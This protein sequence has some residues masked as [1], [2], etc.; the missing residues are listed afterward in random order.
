MRISTVIKKAGLP[1]QGGGRSEQKQACCD[2]KIAAGGRLLTAGI[3]LKRQVGRAEFE[4]GG[5]EQDDADDIGNHVAIADAPSQYSRAGDGA[6]NPIRRSNIALHSASPV[7]VESAQDCTNPTYNPSMA[8]IRILTRTREVI[9]VS[10]SKAR[11]P[12]FLKDLFHDISL[13]TWLELSETGE[14]LQVL[15]KYAIGRSVSEEERKRALEQ[16]KDLARTIPA[17]G[18]FMLPGGAILLP[19]VAK[20][21]PWRLMPSAF[22][23]AAEPSQK[24]D[25]PK[26]G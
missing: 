26:G 24:S 6:N 10:L 14:M 9:S 22:A 19:L 1:T 25:P 2:L 23:D 13:R 3:E 18:I 4:D 16:A 5:S 20:L 12:R 17:F 7:V 21:V 11:D 8:E 15:H